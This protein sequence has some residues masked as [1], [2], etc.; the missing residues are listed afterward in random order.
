M[1]IVAEIS[2]NHCQDLDLALKL[3][4]AAKD[5][6]ADMV[7][8]QTYTA[9][10]M[11]ADRNDPLWEAY[12]NMALSDEIH[13]A[14]FNYG[15]QLGIPVFSTP[16]SE[17]DLYFLESLGC[18]MYKVASLEIVDLDLIDAIARTGKPIILST[19]G[20]TVNEIQTALIA[21]RKVNRFAD[22][23]LLKCTSSYPAKIEDVNLK[24]MATMK[25]M[26]HDDKVGYSDHTGSIAVCLAAAVLG[27]DM[28]EAHLQLSPKEYMDRPAP[29]KFSFYPYEFSLMVSLVQKAIAS[30]G[31]VSFG[32]AGNDAYEYRRSLYF[33]HD[34]KGGDIITKDVIRTAR[35]NKGLHPIVADKIYG[36]RARR[37]IKAGEPVTEEF[38]P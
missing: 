4:K 35:P 3:V 19:G 16:F 36:Q 32:S 23:T 24:T 38:L 37:D 7:K 2:G 29:D 6:G 25:S 13:E 10:S 17:G 34:L 15:K 27:A 8:L 28:I 18:P 14:M 31:K 33:S 20:A 5:S 11:V 21:I 22:I 26:F 1:K 30:L 9:D 12:D